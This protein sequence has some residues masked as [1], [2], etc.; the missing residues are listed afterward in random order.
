MRGIPRSWLAKRSIVTHAILFVYMLDR[1]FSGLKW[2]FLVVSAGVL[3][4]T[5]QECPSI[6]FL[7]IN[8]EEI[9]G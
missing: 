1:K 7:Q 9:C 4:G 8:L 5:N 2:L 6:D 3:N